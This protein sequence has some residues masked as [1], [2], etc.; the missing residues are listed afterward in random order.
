MYGFANDLLLIYYLPM[1]N[2]LSYRFAYDLLFDLLFWLM[3]YCTI[4]YFACDL[5]FH[6]PLSLWFSAWFT[7]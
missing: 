3:I 1:I 5:L 4:N 7:I 2:R 6:L